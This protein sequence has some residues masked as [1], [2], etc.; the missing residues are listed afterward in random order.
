M[1]AIAIIIS[2]EDIKH[3]TCYKKGLSTTKMD[4]LLMLLLIIH[5][6][7]DVTNNTYKLISRLKD[8]SKYSKKG[9]FM[10]TVE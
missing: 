8:S 10:C 9:N 1:L 4:C 6:L 5:F 7:N 2:L 3:K